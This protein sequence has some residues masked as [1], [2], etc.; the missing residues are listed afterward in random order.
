[1]LQDACQLFSSLSCH[2]HSRR[3]SIASHKGSISGASTNPRTP[4][5]R[6]H[7]CGNSQC[8]WLSNPADRRRLDRQPAWCRTHVFRIQFRRSGDD[9]LL[10]YTC[11]ACRVFQPTG[12]LC[13]H[14]R[15]IDHAGSEQPKQHVAVGQSPRTS[16]T[17]HLRSF[18]PAASPHEN[19]RAQNCLPRPKATIPWRYAPEMC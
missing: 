16:H 10:W 7:G 1:M 19:A 18:L 8:Q 4:H 6:R 15:R 9:H 5:R 14:G 13:G 3:S 12:D 17:R 11:E 2:N